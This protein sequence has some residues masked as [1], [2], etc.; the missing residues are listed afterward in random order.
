MTDPSHP[1]TSDREYRNNLLI[2]DGRTR[3]HYDAAGRLI[4]KTTTR[5]SRKPASW[6]YH[7]NAFDQLTD[8]WTPDHQWWHYTYDALGR[9]TTKQRLS[10]DG[11]VLERVD[12]TW[13]GTQ[14]I[15]QATAVAVTRWQYQPDSY[16]PIT[17][18]TDQATINREFF[19]IITDLVG[20]PTE[21]IDPA[22]GL[23][24]AT[25]TTT[26]WGTPPGGA[27]R[28]HRCASPAKS[29][30]QKPDSTTT[31]TAPTIRAAEDSSPKTPWALHPHPTQTRTH[32]IPSRG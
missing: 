26:L 13:D 27:Q 19:A 29:M 32:T 10:T 12:Y 14:L 1:N 9:R 7:Y 8:V 20:T 22:T 16:T 24:A 28:T 18:T 4:R 6:H 3:Y 5:L 2:R 15:E 25:A 23:I 17:Q 21:L 31:I 30:T 11:T